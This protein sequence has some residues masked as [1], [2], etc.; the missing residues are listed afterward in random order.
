MAGI[1][2]FHT[3]A[4]R[5]GIPS[6]AVQ[7]L[8]A[9]MGVVPG[10]TVGTGAV[11]SEAGVQAARRLEAAKHGLVLW[12]N[13]VGQIMDE[14]NVPVR[15][16]LA[17]DNKATNKV[18]KSSDLI[19]IRPTQCPCGLTYGV[20]TAE[21]TKHPGWTYGGD[22]PCSCK[23]HKAQCKSCHERGQMAFIQ[24]VLAKGGI[25]RFVTE[26]DAPI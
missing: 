15:F 1:M 14:R 26:G 25:A 13:N 6:A 22:K 21:E 12:R 23:P 3:W 20:F 7:E 9:M 10:V 8:R 19:G 17:N 11:G 16:G 5:W 18:F 24:F 2:M 4:T